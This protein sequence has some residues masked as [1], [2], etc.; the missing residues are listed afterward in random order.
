M[1]LQS[2]KSVQK[3]RNQYKADNISYR[4]ACFNRRQS[5]DKRFPAFPSSAK[6][7]GFN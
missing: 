5:I 3:N 7:E 6:T 1:K 4:S 2:I